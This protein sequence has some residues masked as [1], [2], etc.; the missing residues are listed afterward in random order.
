MLAKPRVAPMIRK[1][2]AATWLS[3]ITLIFLASSV[4]LFIR[5]KEL[6]VA[7]LVITGI[8][9][10]LKATSWACNNLFE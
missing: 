9:A 10:A 6:R 8:A 5:E 7:V 2:L 4:S 1:I 3:L